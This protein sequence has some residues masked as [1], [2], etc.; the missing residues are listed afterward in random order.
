MQGFAL[1]VIPSEVEESLQSGAGVPPTIQ[2]STFNI[3]NF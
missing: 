1:P 2:N 3:Q